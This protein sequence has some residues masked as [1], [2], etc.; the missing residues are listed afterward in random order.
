MSELVEFIK[1]YALAH[2]EDGGW[3]VIVECWT[4]DEILSELVERSAESVAGAIFI[5][6]QKAEIYA[7]GQADARNSA[8]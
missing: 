3:D 5:F 4:D 8:F 7:D 6:R 1:A 2:Y